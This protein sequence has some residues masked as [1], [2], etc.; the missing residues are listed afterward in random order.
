MMREDMT[1]EKINLTF[2]EH[3]YRPG[4]QLE[5]IVPTTIILAS[6]SLFVGDD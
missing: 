6:S 5:P 1:V 2:I 3:F 4:L